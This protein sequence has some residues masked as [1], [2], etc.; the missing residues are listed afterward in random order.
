MIMDEGDVLFFNG[1]VVHG[2][3]P[4]ISK[5]RFR[6][7]LIGHYIVGNAE[8]VAQYYHPVLRMD[9]TA[10]CAVVAAPDHRL[11]ERPYAFVRLLPGAEPPTLEA[12]REHM[13]RQKW[14]EGLRVG[15][16]FPRTPSG[17]IQ[18]FVLRRRLRDEQAG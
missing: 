7:A 18:K 3:F 12:V 14:P 13:A 9:G 4:N 2:S 5:D 15:E 17:K 1:Q 10:E 6:R 11:G 8:K 16:D